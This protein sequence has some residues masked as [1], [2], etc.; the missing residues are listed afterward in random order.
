MEMT[1]SWHRVG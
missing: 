1:Y